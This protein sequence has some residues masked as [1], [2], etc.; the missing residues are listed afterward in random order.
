MVRMGNYAVLRLVRYRMIPK[1]FTTGYY[2]V[3][4][5]LFDR[6]N[7]LHAWVVS[8][9][10]VFHKEWQTVN[11]SMNT[12]LKRITD[13][14][15]DIRENN[16]G[17]DLDERVEYLMSSINSREKPNCHPNPLDVKSVMERYSLD[18]SSK[19]NHKEKDEDKERCLG[20][21]TLEIS[22]AAQSRTRKENKY[23]QDPSKQT[24]I[25]IPS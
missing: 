16:N 11:M 7:N 3:C 17:R 10:G 23:R 25:S 13:V 1:T 20:C 15:R 22:N 2:R 6:R 18:S 4:I 21:Y 24:Q 19:R 12:Y 9:K 5:I 8:T 14:A